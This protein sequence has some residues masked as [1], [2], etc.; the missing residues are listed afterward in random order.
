MTTP[1]IYYKQFYIIKKINYDD[2]CLIYRSYP[3]T[4]QLSSCF[5][6]IQNVVTCSTELKKIPLI[7]P[8]L[9][10]KKEILFPIITLK[11]MSHSRVILGL[12]IFH[13]PVHTLHSGG[14]PMPK[15][16]SSNATVHF[17]VSTFSHCSSSPKK[18]QC[19]GS[20]RVALLALVSISLPAEV[21]RLLLLYWTLEIF[22]REKLSLLCDVWTEHSVT[23]G[24]Y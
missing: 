1:L 10:R 5:L 2:H 6:S 12:W 20:P 16:K 7:N 22:W 19:A 23:G 17:G 15:H 13:Y 9:L 18:F 21:V 11:P 24:G 14:A 4:V 8:T 3:S